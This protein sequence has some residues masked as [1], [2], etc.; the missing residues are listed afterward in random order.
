MLRRA[1]ALAASLDVGTGATGGATDDA[2]LVERLGVSVAVVPGEP[3]NLKVTTP[4]DLLVVRALIQ[5]QAD[6]EMQADD[7]YDAQQT[8][9]FATV[10]GAVRDEGMA[11]GG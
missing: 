8:A 10:L 9:R 11:E 2:A 3:Q 5:S 1:H 7:R 6:I 4:G